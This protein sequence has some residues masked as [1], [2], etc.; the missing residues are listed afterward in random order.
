MK[1]DVC[2]EKRYW[3][4]IELFKNG[5]KC[6]RTH[7]PIVQVLPDRLLAPI[8]LGHL[9]PILH[10]VPIHQSARARQ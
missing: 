6:R 1:R 2:S 4:R 8:R 7:L 3:D 10:Q 9:V 5:V